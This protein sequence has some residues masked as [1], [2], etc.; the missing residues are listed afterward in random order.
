MEAT[1]VLRLG[2]DSI[3]ADNNRRCS[4][5]KRLSPHLYT[6][7]QIFQS[8][9]RCVWKRYTSQSY[10]GWLV[11]PFQITEQY[12]TRQNEHEEKQNNTIIRRVLLLQLKDQQM[13]SPDIV[14]LSFLW[15]AFFVHK[16][17]NRWM[18]F[19][20]TERTMYCDSSFGHQFKTCAS[21]GKQ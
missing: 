4:S 11:S 17:I 8:P 14:W 6:A 3:I 9:V 5:L 7:D 15:T 1:V 21:H 12:L 20:P 16:L 13:K 10:I 2:N 19:S 18:V